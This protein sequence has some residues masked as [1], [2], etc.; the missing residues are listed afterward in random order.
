MVDTADQLVRQ[1]DWHDTDVPSLTSLFFYNG[2]MFFTRSGQTTMFRRGFEPESDIVGQ[3]RFTIPAVSGMNFSTMRGAFV[4]NDKFYF[5]T[6]TGRMYRADWANRSPVANTVVQISGPDRDT[7]NWASR[8]LFTFEGAAT[9]PENRAPTAAATAS[10]TNLV[11]SFNGTASTD[12]DGDTLSYEWDF[13]DDT[14]NGTGA[15]TTHTYDEAFAGTR[16]VTLTVKDPDGLTASTTRT[17]TPQVPVNQAPTA[18]ATASCTNLV[19]SFNGT[20]STD[21]D[22]DTLS[23]EWDFDDDTANGTGAT[24]THTYDEAFA[25]TRTVTLTVKDP[26]GLTAS[27]TRTITPQVPAN[28]APTAAATI[29]CDGLACAFDAGDSADPDGSVASYA[30][31]FGET[32]VSDGSGVTTT[33]TYGE[34]GDRTVTLT[35]T[36]NDGDIGTKTYSISPTDEANP[37]EFVAATGLNGNRADHTLTIPSS[38]QAGDAL[39]LF[40]AANTTTPTYAGPAGWT[41]IEATNTGI[42]ARAYTK[43]ATAADAGAVVRVTSSA[44]AKAD[45]EVAVYRGTDPSDPVAVSASAQDAGGTTHTS[46]TLTAP[47]GNNTLLTYWADKSNDTSAWTA[48][49]GQTRRNS[50][51]GTGSGH[52][53]GLITD[54]SGVTGSTGGLTATANSSSSR[55]VS[56]SVVLH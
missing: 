13:D 48:P 2:E 22:G 37:V 3:Q 36:D 15:T 52:M 29:S 45:M 11:C 39:V 18:A 32:G 12:P 31:N 10:C 24:T 51:F 9:E 25:G 33:H 42:V 38:V 6:S 21:P 47:A 27:T 56:F 26:D 35:V 4:A 50:K 7:Q 5:A 8:A 53:S 49:A 30:W 1:T 46:P 14:A 41:Q 16:T 34:A 43:V 44:Y 55:G 23:Y 19:C 40:F 17:I 28:Q 20:A 54:Q